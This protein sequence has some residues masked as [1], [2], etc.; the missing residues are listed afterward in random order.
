[1][2]PS[3]GCQP[4]QPWANGSVPLLIIRTL[5]GHQ[6]QPNAERTMN[7]MIQWKPTD[8]RSEPYRVA[9]YLNNPLVSPKGCAKLDL[10]LTSTLLGLARLTGILTL[11]Q[12]EGVPRQSRYHSCSLTISHSLRAACEPVTTTVSLLPHEQQPNAASIH[13]L[14]VSLLSPT[15]STNEVWLH[16]KIPPASPQLPFR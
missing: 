5:V 3:G 10:R 1:M 9:Q 6:Q 2:D 7:N 8:S 14:T 11:I 4:P 15:C 13:P 16:R 12:P